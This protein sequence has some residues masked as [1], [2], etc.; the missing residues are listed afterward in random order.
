M[1]KVVRIAI[2]ITLAGLVTAVLSGAIATV[3]S[4]GV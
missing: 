3:A 2:G 4:V 1:N